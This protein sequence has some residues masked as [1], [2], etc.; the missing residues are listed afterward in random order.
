MQF[1]KIEKIKEGKATV[2]YMVGSEVL[3]ERE[4]DNGVYQLG[5][6]EYVG[7]GTDVGIQVI[8]TQDVSGSYDIKVSS[9][10]T[11]GE[12]MLRRLREN[13]E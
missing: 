11:R 10:E 5:S 3:Y 7:K 2:V 4:M 9:R 12:K 8:A 1:N 6:I 13:M